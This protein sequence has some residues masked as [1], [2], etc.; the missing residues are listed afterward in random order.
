[1]P[2]YPITWDGAGERK[3]ESGVDHGVLYLRNSTT[4]A[5]ENG[6]AWDGLISVSVSPESR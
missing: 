5:Y 6:V 2:T 4:G 1:M 3:Y